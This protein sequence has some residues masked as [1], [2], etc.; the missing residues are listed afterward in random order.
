VALLKP[1][2][3]AARPSTLTV[4]V[5]PVIVGGAI[6]ADGDVFAWHVFLVVVTAAV[7]IQI[8]VNFA[9]DLADARSGADTEHRIGPT[10]TVATGLISHQAMIRGI[11]TAFATAAVAG[12]YLIAVAGWVI[13]AIGIASIAAALGYT[14]GPWPY[15][16]HGLGE[17]F[18]FV[19][20][21]P[22]ATTG[23][24]YAFDRTVPVSAWVGGVV[25]GCFAAAILEANNA[26]DVDTDRA[27]GKR[28]LAVILGRSR[29]SVLYA[30]TLA[31]AYAAIA[32]GAA[33]GWLPPWSALG[34]VTA[35]LAVPLM[36]A[37]ASETSGP[38]LIAALVGTA[39]LQLLTAVLLAAG[40]LL[41]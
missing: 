15:G 7:A 36:R 2:V 8:G 24:R 10:R 41:G 34:L 35:P 23:T 33:T 20:F 29:A 21:G 37:V 14:A 3:V 17:V 38:P 9:N 11:V 27:A 5:A 16:Y 26:R 31:A 22:V 30:A 28:T 25:M 4:A 13:A 18:T 12:A 19:F 32:A 40:I 39:R 6:A 1:W